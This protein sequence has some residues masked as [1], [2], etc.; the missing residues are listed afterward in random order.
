MSAEQPRRLLSRHGCFAHNLAMRLAPRRTI[1]LQQSLPFEGQVRAVADE[2]VG[3]HHDREHA[4]DSLGH[5]IDFPLSAKRDAELTKRFFGKAL[6][7]P[8][9]VIPRAITVDKNPPYPRAVAEMKAGGELWRFSRL[10]QCTDLNNI[11]EQDH[12]RIK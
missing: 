8:H 7:Q 4:V 12:R 6:A 1:S 9:T 10:R 3:V 11:L 5:A 2:D